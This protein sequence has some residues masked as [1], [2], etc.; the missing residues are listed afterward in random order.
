MEKFSIF[1]LRNWVKAVLG[2]IV[3]VLLVIFAEKWYASQSCKKVSIVFNDEQK[4][5]PLLAQQDIRNLLSESGKKPLEGRP[6]DQIDLNFLENR[7]ESSPLVKDCQISR[8]LRGWLEVRVET[9]RPVARLVQPDL[10]DNG[11]DKYLNEEG[12]FMPLSERYTARVLLISG[13]Y[14]D[15]K[16]HLQAPQDTALLNLVR[17]IDQDSLWK[18]QIEWVEVDQK[19]EITMWPQVGDTPI[20]FGSASSRDIKFQ[21][22]NLF[23]RNILPLRGWNSFSRVSVKYKNQVVCTRATAD[24]LA[25]ATP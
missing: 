8:N 23:F 19:G 25:I 6:F 9:H 20:E 7:V 16:N 15:R 13:P 3:M 4:Q 2:I 18:A 5:L 12:R 10:P 24:S 1:R 21:K 17:A 22:I 11:L 14:F